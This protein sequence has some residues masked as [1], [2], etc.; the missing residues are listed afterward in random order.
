MVTIQRYGIPSAASV[1]M[2]RDTASNGTGCRSAAMVQP[3]IRSTGAS[4]DDAIPH[5]GTRTIPP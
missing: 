3:A 4:P 1:L 5:H 2:D